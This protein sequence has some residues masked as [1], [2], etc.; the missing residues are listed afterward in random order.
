MDDR[1]ASVESMQR[2]AGHVQSE[3]CVQ[4][5]EAAYLRTISRW[6]SPELA[7]CVSDDFGLIADAVALG[8]ED[9]WIDG[10]LK[11]YKA[12]EIPCTP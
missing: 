2:I 1:L 9:P 5:R 7:A 12:G 3:L 10:I 11:K 6:E 4:I 8:I